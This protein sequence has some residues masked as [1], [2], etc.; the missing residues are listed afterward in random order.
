MRLT[1][2]DLDII[3][4]LKRVVVADTQTILKIFF[5]DASLRTCQARLKMLVDNKS[6]SYYIMKP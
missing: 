2:R 3:D 6:I 5:K 1:E 4:F